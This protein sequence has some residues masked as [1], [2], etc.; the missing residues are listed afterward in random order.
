[1]QIL[2]DHGLPKTTSPKRVLIVG[3]GIAGLVSAKLLRDA[4][5]TVTIL[6]ANA[7]RTG[8]RIKTFRGV[9]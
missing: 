5:H 2:I 9:F 1:L 6:E 4:G 3:A 7:N 8:G